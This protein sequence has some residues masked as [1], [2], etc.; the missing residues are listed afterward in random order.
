MSALNTEYRNYF[1]FIDMPMQSGTSDCG[2]YA[3]AFATAL[4][5]GKQPECYVFNEQKMR[6]HLRRCLIGGRMEMLK[7]FYAQ[8]RKYQS[9]TK[10][11]PFTALAVCPSKRGES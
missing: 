1:E 10:Q 2:V 11:F 6:A 8:R 5:L 4:A 7:C 3:I 9:N